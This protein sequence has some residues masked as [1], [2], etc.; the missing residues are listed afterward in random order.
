[1]TILKGTM[2]VGGGW[3]KGSGNSGMEETAVVD[4]P[5]GA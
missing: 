1:M 4:F 3:K 2:G 5:R